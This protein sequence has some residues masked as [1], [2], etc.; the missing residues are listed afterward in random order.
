KVPAHT[1]G[2]CR[3]NS[4]GD[5]PSSRRHT[6]LNAC[7]SGI[8][9]VAATTVIDKVEDRSRCRA[10]STRRRASARLEIYNRVRLWR[11][12]TGDEPPYPSGL[13]ALR[14]GWRLF[15]A[16]QLLP[17]HPGA[18]YSTSFLKHEFFFERLCAAA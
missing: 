2:R 6:L 10:R 18:E 15:Q 11:A 9:T 17:P 4:R 1:L 5:A 13:A 16:S 3:R 14:D 7:R 12:L 8:P